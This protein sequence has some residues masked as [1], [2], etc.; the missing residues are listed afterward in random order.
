[1]QKFMK[2]IAAIMLTVAVLIA[3]GC[4]KNENN[5]NNN[6]KVTTNAPQ[7]ITATSATISGEVEGSLLIDFGVCWGTMKNPTLD[8]NYL[9]LMYRGEMFTFTIT[10]LEP[11]TG[12]HVRAYAYDGNEVY[13]GSDQS[14]TTL[15]QE[16]NVNVSA[17]PSFG[18]SVSVNNNGTSGIFTHNHPCTVHATSNA[19]YSFVKWAENGETVSIEADYTFN[20]TEN[21]TLEAYFV[22]IAPEGAISGLFTINANGDQVY[23]SQGNLQYQAS[24][25]T[26]KFAENQYD[27]I[28][29]ANSNISSTYS[30]WIDL[31]G[32]GTSGYHD[33]NDNYNVNYQPWSTSTS[34]VSGSYNQYGYGP[35]NNMPDLDLTGTSSSYDWG[36][37]NAIS[38][39]GNTTQQWRTLT[40]EEWNYVLITR[41]NS[42][43]SL[44]KAQVAGV[45]GIILLPDDWSASTYSLNSTNDSH[46]GFSSNI[47]S[48]L[49]WQTLE[50]EGAVFLPA[51]GDRDGITVYEGGDFGHYWSATHG[52]NYWSS[53]AWFS[54]YNIGIGS[55]RRY[56]GQSV[57][58]VCPAN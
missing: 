26:W 6:V 3:V 5:N 38:N 48:A 46:V 30:G 36:V 31:F 57:R 24:T 44:A 47:I 20:V 8:D 53:D 43:I 4:N 12:Y 2:A 49:L 37:Y 33:A 23:F 34:Y 18:G 52:A 9:S 10:G 54:V 7:D 58:L 56:R 42:C 29:S 13:Y 11:N 35:S 22:Y 16:Y 19:G 39:G 41:M 21:R 50:N 27:C 25:N 55:S 14:F 40:R 28:G 17:H 1:M 45:N 51:A 32:W 15:Q